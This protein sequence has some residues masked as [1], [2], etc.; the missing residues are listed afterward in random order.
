MSDKIPMNNVA[1]NMMKRR[2]MLVDGRYLI[3]YSFAP[4]GG[5]DPSQ[6]EVSQGA[7]EPERHREES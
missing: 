5:S 7:A 1:E 3:L 4:P 6:S 2:L